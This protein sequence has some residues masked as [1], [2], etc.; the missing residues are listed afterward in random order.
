MKKIIFTLLLAGGLLTSCDMDKKPFG[1]LDDTTALQSVNDCYRFRNGLYSSLR[2]ITAGSYLYFPEIQMDIFQ[3]IV[4]NGNREG[5]FS[6]GDIIS[7]DSD[8]ESFWASMYTRINSANYLIEKID[9]LLE[10][11]E[12]TDDDKATLKRY[13]AE[14][15]FTRAYCYY[16]LADHFCET[17]SSANADSEGMGLPLVSVYNPTADR[18]K[19]PGRSTQNETYAFI[20]AD[21]EEAYSELLAYEKLDAQAAP[22]QNASY[23]NSNTVLALQARIALLKGD[24]KTAL[25]KAETV[26]NCGV[27]ALTSA[28]DYKK[29]W[30]ED[31]GT[32]VIFRPFMS[33]TE[34]GSSTGSAFLSD[35][36][37]SADYIP[38]F[39][40]L[41]M[42]DDNDVRFDAFFTP[43]TN[44]KSNGSLI[45]A[46]AFNKFPG[47]ESLKTSSARNFVNMTKPFRLS[48]LYLIA[49]EAAN[50]DNQTEKANKYLND[51]RSE[52]I[53]DYESVSLTGSTLTQ[54]IR[55][56]RFKELIGEGF[57]ISDL[58]RWKQGFTRDSSYPINPVVTDAFVAAGKSVS[59]QAGDHRFVWPIPSDEIQVNPQLEGQQNAGY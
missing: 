53:T 57:R 29:L 13:E 33:N 1:S 50:S 54:A 22:A 36:E 11:G 51:L 2:A 58:R 28:A 5:N 17:Y 25:S 26:I 9:G 59:Y 37:E 47:N 10:T 44:L 27:Y 40:V 6:N 42:Y 32:E 20:E 52:R 34:L 18:S 46:Y 24:K 8:I 56:E 3:G 45:A 35:S 4:G 43:Y 49:A 41:E 48:E 19:Y 21:L 31:T 30:S 14:A 39:N 16:W 55:D 23:V 15:L 38:C 12:W 7:S